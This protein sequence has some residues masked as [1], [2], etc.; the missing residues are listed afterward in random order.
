MVPL[1]TKFSEALQCDFGWLGWFV[2]LDCS[3]VPSVTLIRKGVS[4][5]PSVKKKW[6]SLSHVQ[7]FV[8]PWTIQSMNSLGQNMGVGSLSV[9]QGI[10]PT[11]GSNPALPHCRQIL[12]QLSL[13]WS[14]SARSP[15]PR[16]GKKT[17]RNNATCNR[18]IYYWL[19]PGPPALTKAVRTKGPQPQFSQ[20]FIGYNYYLA[21]VGWLHSG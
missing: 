5:G 7:L 3:L 1:T 19:E 13:Q 6:K 15:S 14:C 11:Q 12:Y 20:V 16:S 18:G 8:T 9:L 2:P 17:P 21:Q 10:I 4:S